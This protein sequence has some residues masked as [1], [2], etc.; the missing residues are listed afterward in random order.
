MKR[1]SQGKFAVLAVLA[2]AA[3]MLIAGCPAEEE[4]EEMVEFATDHE[5][6][7]RE[8]G[9]PALEEEYGFE[10]DEVHDMAIGL[11]HEALR[12]GDVD[13]AMGFKTDGKIDELDLVNLEDDLGFFPVYNA[14]PVIREEMLEEYPEIEDVLGEIAPELDTETIRELNYR[15]DIEG[16]EPDEVAEEWLLEEGF[17]EE[18]PP[19]PGE[20]EPVVIGSKEF[21]E[22]QTL[23]QISLLALEHAGIPVEDSTN[24]GGTDVNRTALDEGD[25]HLYWEYTGTAWL[26]FFEEEE[27]ISDPDEL[28]QLVRERDEEAGLIWLDYAPLNNVYTIMMREEHADELGIETISELAEWVEAVQAGEVEN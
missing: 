2:L 27:V 13:V 3:G 18:E 6:M 28:Y 16:Y 8:D 14:A 26:T 19:E 17:I 24:L 15:V 10:F 20:G 22:Q 9:L 7:V 1:L 25:T 21:S 12:D 23:G 4:P 5:F 11:T